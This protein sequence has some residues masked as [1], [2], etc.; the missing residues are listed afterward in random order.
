MDTCA[1]SA[2]SGWLAATRPDIVVMHLG[3]N[4]VWS[5][6]AAATIL[7]AFTTLVNQMRASNPA[8][9]IL[10]ARIIP[11]N[12]PTCPDCAQRVVAFDNAIPA[13]AAA[14]TTA[15]SPITVVDLWTGFS[16]STDTY[17]GVHPNASGDQKM[18][19]AWYP[20]LTAALSG[21]IPTPTPTSGGGGCA[22]V[23]RITGQWQGGFQGEVTVTNTGASP[24]TGWDVGWTFANGQQVTQ[25]WGGRLRQT[26]PSVTVGNETWNGA[27]APGATTT[28]GFLSSW[29]ATNTPPTPACA[30]A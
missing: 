2:S 14:T 16:T 9:K 23:Y 26:G 27:L 3:T 12:P 4:D 17:D 22:A 18:S 10:V 28:L 30:R 29:T 1:G 6:I 15:Q 19:D 11:M 20:A 21:P 13:W 25:L 7:G 5:N 24:M 8:M